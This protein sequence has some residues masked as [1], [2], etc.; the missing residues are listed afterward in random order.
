[1]AEAREA[2]VD[3]TPAGFEQRINHNTFEYKCVH[4]VIGAD[5]PHILDSLLQPNNSFG[6]ILLALAYDEEQ[7]DTL[8]G[9]GHKAHYH[10]LFD[11]PRSQETKRLIRSLR[12]EWGCQPRNYQKGTPE[13]EA[14]AAC[15]ESQSG[16]W[17][18]NCDFQIKTTKPIL[19]WAH[20]Q[21][22][23]KYLQD[24]S[25]SITH[26]DSNLG[27]EE[28]FSHADD[29]RWSQAYED[30]SNSSRTSSDADE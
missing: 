28:A 7:P 29:A 24:K 9:R 13:Y 25:P 18:P 11:I 23:Y 3:T 22:C 6:V 12:R 16:Q 5:K 10:V 26:P 19:T 20:A 27:D 15:H 1:M 2:D 21:H 30:N 4:W 8:M 14:A 17:C